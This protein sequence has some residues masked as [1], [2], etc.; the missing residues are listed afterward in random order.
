MST[1]TYTPTAC[2]RTGPLLDGWTLVRFIETGLGRTGLNDDNL[3]ATV[4]HTPRTI[5][6]WRTI[7]VRLATARRIAT[8]FG[9]HPQDIWPDYPDWAQQ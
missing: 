6:R 9:V 3:A 2:V 8:H 1:H 5:H 4:P 7:G